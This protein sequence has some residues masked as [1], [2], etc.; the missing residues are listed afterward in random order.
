MNRNAFKLILFIAV[1]LNF[2]PVSAQ[3]H[4]IVDQRNR[5]FEIISRPFNNNQSIEKECDITVEM[6]HVVNDSTSLP[7]VSKT[8]VLL[9]KEPVRKKHLDLFKTYND[10]PGLTINNL[11][12]E[13]RKNGIKHE[14]VVLA[15]AILETGWFTSYVCR[16][17]NN[18]FGLVNPRTGQFYE[19]DHWTESVKAYY[20]KVQYRYKGGNYLLW[21]DEM[22]YAEKTTYIQALIVLLNQ[23]FI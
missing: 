20:T 3:F 11:L 2:I 16:N 18:L 5:S 10:L 9:S 6:E 14:K 12:R 1:S 17:K 23:Y 7:T 21:L 8:P 4:T 13:I 15:Q 19:F 22:G